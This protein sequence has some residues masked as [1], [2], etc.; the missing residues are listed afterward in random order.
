[1]IKHQFQEEITAQT[2]QQNIKHGK[3]GSSL[4]QRDP[5]QCIPEMYYKNLLMAFE[6]F[7]INQLNGAA[8]LWRYK[9]LAL[10]VHQV[11]HTTP[12]AGSQAHEFL[13]RVLCDSTVNFKAAKWTNRKDSRI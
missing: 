11:L 6:S 2:I 4:I 9:K 12:A 5:K 7:L 1:M 3:V 8:C 13:T 10:H